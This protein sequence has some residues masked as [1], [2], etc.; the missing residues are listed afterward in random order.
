LDGRELPFQE[1]LAGSQLVRLGIAVVGRAAL[2]RV[3]DVD[4]LAPQA[5]R[6]DH[7]G[8]ELTGFTHERLP[9]QIFV[10]ARGLADEHQTRIRTAAQVLHSSE[11]SGLELAPSPRRQAQPQ[12]SRARTRSQMPCATDSLLPD[13]STR[14][15]S[16]SSTITRFTSEAKPPPRC[17]TSLAIIRSRF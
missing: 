8:E 9:F 14:P 5:H 1:R 17:E 15:P 11:Y 4:V 13:S 16:R 2:H 3:A 12:A 7:L 6:L 10:L